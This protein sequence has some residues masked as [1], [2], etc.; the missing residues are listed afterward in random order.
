MEG[1]AGL[2]SAVGG[3]IDQIAAGT[4][5]LL[6]DPA[7]LAAFGAAARRLLG[8]QDQAARMGQAAHARIREQYV[9]DMHLL[10]YA[11]LLGTLIDEG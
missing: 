10:R 11:R 7:D 4:G 1:A 9:G 2:G 3:I 8:D 6:P 5:I